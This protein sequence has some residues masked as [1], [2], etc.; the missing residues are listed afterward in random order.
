MLLLAWRFGS[1]AR[2]P[3]LMFFSD[4]VARKE[5]GTKLKKDIFC[6]RGA[7]QGMPGRYPGAGCTP[8]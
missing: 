6:V 3:S 2:R 5:C 8:A 4:G 1:E 7:S